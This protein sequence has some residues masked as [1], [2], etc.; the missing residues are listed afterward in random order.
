MVGHYGDGTGVSSNSDGVCAA[1]R[2]DRAFRV[3]RCL[4][5][6]EVRMLQPKVAKFGLFALIVLSIGVVIGRFL[7]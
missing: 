5:V 7:L 6:P 1:G 4:S 2:F 3:W